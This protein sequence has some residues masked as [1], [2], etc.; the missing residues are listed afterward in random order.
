[1]IGVDHGIHL[2]H[3]LMVVAIFWYSVL[4]NL[5]KTEAGYECWL[6]AG[7]GLAM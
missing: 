3:R 7:K 5:D 4:D 2:L 1:M 6:F